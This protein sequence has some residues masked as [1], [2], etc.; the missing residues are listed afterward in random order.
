[1]PNSGAKRLNRLWPILAGNVLR[2]PYN[3]KTFWKFPDHKV[4]KK[5]NNKRKLLMTSAI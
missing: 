4:L 5:K 1:M 2:A 3:L